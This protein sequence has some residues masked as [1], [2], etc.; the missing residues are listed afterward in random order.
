MCV[1][2]C[3]G[4]DLGRNLCFLESVLFLAGP[5]RRAKRRGKV[6]LWVNYNSM[7]STGIVFQNGH[8]GKHLE[9][10]LF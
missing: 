2:V 4:V 9:K 3:W 1:H 10:I 5:R 8:Q 6:L 7:I